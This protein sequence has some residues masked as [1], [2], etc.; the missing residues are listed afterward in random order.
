MPYTVLRKAVFAV[1]VTLVLSGCTF[2]MGDFTLVASE[3]VGLEPDVIRRSV[4]GKDCTWM[5]LFIPLGSLVPN[6]EEA[7]DRAMEQVPKGNV[8]TD[9]A[10]YNDLIFTYI[11]NRTCLRVKGD[12]GELK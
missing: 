11:L 1:S 9:V 2:G 8:M 4:E 3:N 7:I 10:V 5:L 12:V 6:A